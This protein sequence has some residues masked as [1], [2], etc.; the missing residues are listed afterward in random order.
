LIVLDTSVW[1]FW[2]ADPARLSRR[3]VRAI[4]REEQ[5]GEI[6]VSVISAWEVALK[7]SIGKLE[8]D[9]DPSS[10]VAIAAAYPGVRLEPLALD[11]ALESTS[12]PGKFHR[13]PADRFIVALAR[14]LRA[15]LVTSDRRIRDYEHVQSI[16]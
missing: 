15:P 3:A 7:H 2:V 6:I 13:D 8:L 11:D 9:R 1:V 5:G 10:W 16:W 12:L 4:T 14:R